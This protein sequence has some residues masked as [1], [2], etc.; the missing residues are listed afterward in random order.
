M[1]ETYL[2][3]QLPDEKEEIIYS[4]S[5]VIT[6]YF[7]KA[8]VLSLDDFQN[9]CSKALNHA[10]KRVYERFGYECTSAL[11]ELARVNSLVEKI[12]NNASPGAEL[13]VKIVSI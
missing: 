8:S 5:T 2:R 4:P 9:Q 6:Q 10:S 13:N 11:G 3:V 7:E 1:P 12:R